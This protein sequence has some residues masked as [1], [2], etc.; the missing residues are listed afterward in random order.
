MLYLVLLKRWCMLLLENEEETSWIS[1]YEL[2][3]QL[4]RKRNSVSLKW[5]RHVFHCWVDI[6]LFAM[7]DEDYLP[8]LQLEMPKSNTY[9]EQLTPFFFL[10]CFYQSMN[11]SLV[12]DN[13]LFWSGWIHKGKVHVCLNEIW[14]VKLSQFRSSFPKYDRHWHS[15]V[16][17]LLV[18]GSFGVWSSTD[19]HTGSW[20]GQTSS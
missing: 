8:M 11:L 17:I 14:K 3:P 7:L 10:S 12:S 9:R 1:W 5:Q 2:M 15:W 16:F 20:N 4:H 13:R 19:L 6:S 18:S